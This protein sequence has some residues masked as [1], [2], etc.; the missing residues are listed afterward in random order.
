MLSRKQTSFL[1]GIFLSRVKSSGLFRVRLP[2]GHILANAHKGAA[3]TSQTAGTIRES[4]LPPSSANL[5]RIKFVT[6]MYEI[7]PDGGGGYVLPVFSPYFHDFFGVCLLF[8]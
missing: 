7:T 4:I 5:R 3:K 1:N 2:F 8:A 6:K